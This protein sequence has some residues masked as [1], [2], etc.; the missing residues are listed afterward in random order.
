MEFSF[1]SAIFFFFKLWILIQKI[2]NECVIRNKII[3]CEK[4]D[5]DSQCKRGWSLNEYNLDIYNKYIYIY[6]VN[7]FFALFVST[8]F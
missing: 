4:V 7:W 2:K 1:L 6:F 3:D 8:M 5:T